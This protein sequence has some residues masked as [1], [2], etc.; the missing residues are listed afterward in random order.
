MEKPDHL[1]F[2]ELLRVFSELRVRGGGEPSTPV[3]RQHRRIKSRFR[4]SSEAF[5]DEEDQSTAQMVAERASGPTAAIVRELFRY[6]NGRR[7]PMSAQ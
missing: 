4:F 1:L 3:S 5:K 7:V 6:P 2:F